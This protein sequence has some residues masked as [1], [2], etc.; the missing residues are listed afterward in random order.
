MWAVQMQPCGGQCCSIC[1]NQSKL[2]LTD[3]CFMIFTHK[4]LQMATDTRYGACNQEKGGVSLRTLMLLTNRAGEYDGSLL[5]SFE[6]F[7][8]QLQQRPTSRLHGETVDP[9]W[10]YWCKSKLTLLYV[11][12]SL[13]GR[14]GT[15][16]LTCQSDAMKVKWKGEMDFW[17]NLN[18]LAIMCSEMITAWESLL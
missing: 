3:S 13:S 17:N 6:T 7:C 18:V 9:A 14:S 12:L 2:V 16:S 11:L 5:S 15:H 10:F 4:L 8:L 1:T